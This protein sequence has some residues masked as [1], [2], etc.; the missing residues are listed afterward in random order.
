M[1][2][3]QLVMQ[4]NTDS[5]ALGHQVLEWERQS[6]SGTCSLEMGRT[7]MQQNRQS[8]TGTCSLKMGTEQVQ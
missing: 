7:V 6:C 8:D 3:E 1:K 2:M 4:R 5:Q